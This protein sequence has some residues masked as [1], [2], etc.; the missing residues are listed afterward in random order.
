[1]CGLAISELIDD[2]PEIRERLIDHVCLF[3]Q[4]PSRS[5][6]H[7]SFRASQINEIQLTTFLAKGSYIS[8]PHSHNKARMGPRAASIHICS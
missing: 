2:F 1:M 3:Q 6:L 7:D 8:L 5:S 4:F